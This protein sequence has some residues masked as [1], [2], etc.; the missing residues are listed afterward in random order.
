MSSV[1]QSDKSKIEDGKLLNEAINKGLMSF[2]PDLM[3][4]QIAK[5]YQLAEQLYGETI[6]K[7]VSGYSAD[8]IRKNI[9]I[10]EFQRELAKILKENIERLKED[11]LLE[12]DGTIAE[13]GYELAA[14]NLYIQ[15]LQN[16]VP[17]GHLGQRVHKHHAHYGERAETRPYRKGDRLK[18]F[19][20]KQSVKIALRRGH[21]QLHSEDLRSFDRQKQGEVYVIYGIDAS[22][23]MKGNKLE[24][25]KKAG[26]ALSYQAISKRDH[27]GLIVFGSEI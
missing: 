7:L 9:N 23:S 1:I 14:Y 27:A 6:L 22:G 4:S 19:A 11:N 12:K 20:A 3:M 18:D 8:Y 5:N 15:E 13:Q 25:A 17:T 16:L 26:V 10:P 21:K 24:A 2:T